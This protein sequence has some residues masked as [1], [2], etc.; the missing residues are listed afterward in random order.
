MKVCRISSRLVSPITFSRRLRDLDNTSKPLLFKCFYALE[1][2]DAQSIEK[3]LHE[4]FDDKRVRQN[5]EFFNC[6]P[7]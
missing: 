2:E 6:T 3:L 4:A 7:E 1:V 5:R